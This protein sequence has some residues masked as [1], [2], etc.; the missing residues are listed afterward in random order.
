MTSVASIKDRLRNQAQKTGKPLQELYTAYGLERTL[1]RLSI[2]EYADRFVLKGGILLYALFG[3]EFPRVTRDIDLLAQHISNEAVSMKEVFRKIFSIEADDALRFDTDNINVAN[4][5]EFKEYHGVN[6]STVAYL[7]RTRIPISI[8]IGFGDVVFP[9][10]EKMDYPVLLNMES[11]VLYAYSKESIIA[12]KFEAI[13]QLGYSNGRLKDFYDI[14]LMTIG[15]DFDG[16][17]VK[18]AIQETFNQRKTLID[19][20][21]FYDEEFLNNALLANRWES[22]KKQKQASSTLSFKETVI[23]IRNF[24]SPVVGSIREDTRYEKHWDHT[25]QRWAD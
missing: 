10:R 3:S 7:D 9:D 13:V 12:E 18:E 4:I 2:S 20:S 5:T 24:L 21:Y 6:V 25:M 19:D 15:F 17:T 22:F 16:A 11:P 1:Y 8:D 14:Q 23:S